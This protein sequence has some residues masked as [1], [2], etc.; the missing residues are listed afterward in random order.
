MFLLNCSG[1]AGENSVLSICQ[2]PLRGK[3]TYC[4]LEEL[5]EE[6]KIWKKARRRSLGKFSFESSMNCYKV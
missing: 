6:E 2:I 3:C 1:T 4:M 5:D